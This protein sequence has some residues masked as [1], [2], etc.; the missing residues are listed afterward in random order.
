M[1]ICFLIR[2]RKEIDSTLGEGEDITAQ[3]IMSMSYLTQV[4]KESLRLHPP[5]P[6][7][8]RRTK[9]D[10]MI[11]GVMIPED[12]PIMVNPYVIQTH[13]D[14]WED[15]SEFKPERFSFD[16]RSSIL[17]HTSHFHSVHGAASHRN[18]QIYK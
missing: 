16:A 2:L 4:V 1:T 7:L 3:D 15:P 10:T 12:T 18:M 17:M 6:A 14:Y 9:K 5:T 13:P 11:D 8:T